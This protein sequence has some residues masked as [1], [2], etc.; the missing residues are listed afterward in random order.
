MLLILDIAYHSTPKLITI[1]I[2]RLMK[3]FL[4]I[5]TTVCTLLIALSSCKNQ[6]KVETQGDLKK[7]HKVTLVFDGPNTNEM[8][9]NNPFLN[10]RL[11]VTFTNGDK[12]YEV[13]VFYA[14]DGN[15]AETSASK[16]NKWMVRF[17]PYKIGTWNYNV[18][19][20][21]G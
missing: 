4:T 6:P 19:F 11:D 21:Q 12:T 5:L 1:E 3:K 14:A 18:S 7:W 20:K 17:T 16:G 9:G 13:P 8:D 15:A 10:Y 2:K